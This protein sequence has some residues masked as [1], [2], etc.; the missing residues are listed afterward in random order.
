VLASLST[1]SHRVDYPANGFI[2]RLVGGSL[3]PTNQDRERKGLIP[4]APVP[5][6]LGKTKATRAG[7]SPTTAPWKKAIESGKY[8]KFRRHI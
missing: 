8:S 4:T 2:R 1:Y 3:V 7:E 5:H 6:V